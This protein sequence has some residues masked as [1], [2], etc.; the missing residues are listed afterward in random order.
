MTSIQ[1]NSKLNSI[2]QSAMEK[3]VDD[4]V[5]SFRR[6]TTLSEEQIEKIIQNLSNTLGIGDTEV[7]IGMSLLFLQGAASAGAPLTM[8][9]DLG[10]GKYLEKRNIIIA[11]ELVT[12]HKFIRR[13][14]ETL[15]IQIGNFATQNKLMGEL[16]YRINNKFKADTGD[17]LNEKELAF[18]SSFSQA[19]PNL[20]E[21]TSDRLAKL[22][23]GDYQQRFEN[24]KRKNNENKNDNKNKKK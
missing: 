8:S 13:I 23:A 14:A 17:S 18:C 2:F 5:P 11:C 16:G 15:A 19:I 24:K 10:N 9:I 6:K 20:S 3:K 4:I 12:G 7:L 1:N 22:L 21:I